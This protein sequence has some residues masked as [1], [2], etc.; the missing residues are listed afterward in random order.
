MRGT[1]KL[2]T[3]VVAL[4]VC[5]SLAAYRTVRLGDEV[6]FPEGHEGWFLVEYEV[7]GEPPLTLSHSKYVI[8]LPQS[9]IVKTSSHRQVG[10]GVDRYY[11][12]GPN[13]RQEIPVDSGSCSATDLCVL[14][15]KYYSGPSQTTALLVGRKS[16]IEKYQMPRIPDRAF[17]P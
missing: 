16:Q 15:T 4:L 6:L 3:L 11:F 9:G 14:Q 2:A 10:Y 13:T 12:E 5:F 7:P 8:R 1:R 17:K